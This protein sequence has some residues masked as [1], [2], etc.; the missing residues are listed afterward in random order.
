MSCKLVVGTSAF[1]AVTA[2]AL[3]SPAPALAQ[4][5][6]SAEAH[7]A[8]RIDPNWAPPR[9]P[10]GHPDLQG[11]WTTDDMRGVPQQRADEFGTRQYVSDAEFAERA[12]RRE[13]ARE[14]QDRGAAGTFRN[15]EGTRTFGYTSMVIDPPDGKIPAVVAQASERRSTP[16]SFGLGPFNTMADFSLYDRCITRGVVGSFSPAVYGNGARIVQT[17]DTVAISYEMV[18]DTRVIPLDARPA[19]SSNF[20]LLM[21][22]SRAHFEG[23][24]LVIESANFTDRTAI[25]GVRHSEQLKLTERFTRIDPQMIDYEIRVDDPLTWEKP[26]TMRMTITQQPGYEIYEYSCHEGNL[27]MRHALMGER[28]Y[29]RAAAEAAAKGLPPPERVFERVNGPDRAR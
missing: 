3:G 25:G 7:A 19:L 24:T 13:G 6:A 29:E 18:H 15:E 22:D 28:A 1:V 9:T 16:G 11:I 27:A 12:S 23:N 4:A 17:P 2:A 21:G 20:H 26:W 5:E 14:I 8:A 10:W